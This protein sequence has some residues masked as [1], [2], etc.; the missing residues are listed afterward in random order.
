MK[1]KLYRILGVGLTVILLFSLMTIPASA[2]VS[3]VTLAVAPTTISA[4]AAYT[5]TFSAGTPVPAGGTITV[6]FDTGIDI[7]GITDTIADSDVTVAST[8]GIGGT[9]SAGVAENCSSTVAGQ[10]LTITTVTAF[11][12]GSLVQVVVQT[13]IKNPGTIGTYGMTIATSAET[14]AVPTPTFTTTAP[15]ILPLPGVVE[16][17]NSANVLMQQTNV[18]QTAINAASAGDTI[19]VGAGTYD[20]DL[21]IGVS[22]TLLGDAAT[23]IIKDTDGNL[24][25]GTVSITYVGTATT[26]VVF[27]GFTVMGDLG[28]GNA[29]SITGHKVTVKNCIFTKAGTATTAVAQNMVNYAPGALPTLASAITN[30]VFDTS[31]G[32]VVD[33]GIVVAAGANAIGLTVSGCTFTV[34]GAIGLED[35]A[36]NTSGAGTA[37][38]PILISD[39]NIAGASGI[40]VTVTAGTATVSGNNL[41]GLNQAVTV[42]AGTATIT[43]NTIDNCGLAVSTTA[44]SGQA[45]IG[46]TATTALSITNNTITNCPNDIIEIV[47]NSENINMMFNN[48]TDNAIGID[49]NDADTAQ[50]LN[51]T[52]NWWGAAT[53]PAT[54]FNL[55]A[56]AVNNTAAYLGGEATGNFALA[57]ATLVTKTTVGV[58]VTATPAVATAPA[59]IGVANY[60]ANPQAATPLPAIDGGFY[61][62]YLADATAGDT[63]SVLVKFY[64]ANISANTTVYVWGTLGGGWQP[65]TAT[66]QGVNLFEGYAYANISATTT[67]SVAALAGTPFALCEAPVA[68]LPAPTLLSPET[69][70]DTVPLTPT[71]AWE[72][73]AAADGYYFEFADNA[74]FV[75]PLVKLDGDY[76]RLIVTAYHYVTELPYSTPYYWRVKAVSGTEEAGNL[77]QSA[78]STSVFVTMAEPEEPVPPVVI[79]PSEPPVIEM[80]ETPPPVIEPIVEVVTPPATPITPAWIYAI[81]GVGAVLVIAV[82]VL[83]VRTR[84]VA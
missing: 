29:L 46:V 70:D 40:G 19:K 66:A 36:I 4:A 6:T 61:D 78:W 34:D 64:N 9:G 1:R 59:I 14:T 30:C 81:I 11:G 68:A 13:N 7:S 48:L 73:V 76:G 55:T 83:I 52:H 60:A 58:D 72:A 2:T 15:T 22:V 47:D 62:V 35:S 26:G 56:G 33:N 57:S 67:P 49:N 50:T 69:G 51:A 54:G 77:A 65:V 63:A 12:S 3:G 42:T 24:T 41:M 43:G 79:E 74:N 17:Y 27:D 5:I 23:T 38:L 31:L 75:A 32:T 39:N 28:G 21:T 71:F 16:R 37:A 82:I 53:G 18:I 8:A 80:P 44:P 45:A 25:G 10:V 84:R 20:E